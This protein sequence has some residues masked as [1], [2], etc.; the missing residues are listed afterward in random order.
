MAADRS[1]LGRARL[2]GIIW[3][4]RVLAEVSS[5]P[6]NGLSME[7]SGMEAGPARVEQA[8][9]MASQGI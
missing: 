2:E 1:E 4:F 3:R 6:K 9:E 8:E 5:H 7:C